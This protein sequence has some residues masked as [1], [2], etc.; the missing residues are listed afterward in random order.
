M[1]TPVDGFDTD[2]ETFLGL[3]NGF[4]NPQAVFT[5][6][7]G[8]SIASGWQPMAAHQVKVS[9]APGEERR[10]NFV[11]RRSAAGGEVRRAQRHQQSPRKSP[12]GEAD[13]R[14]ADCRS[15]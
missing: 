14:R 2:M 7:M 8:N 10:F 13:D 3:Y 9:L 11:L 4:E 5:G 1:N 6:K 12:A 15:V